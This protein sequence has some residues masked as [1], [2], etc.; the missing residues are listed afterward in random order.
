MAERGVEQAMPYCAHLGAL[1]VMHRRLKC[2]NVVVE[3]GAGRLW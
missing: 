2:L 1:I 3:T